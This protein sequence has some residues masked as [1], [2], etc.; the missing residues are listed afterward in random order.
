MI[1][2]YVGDVT[3]HL[4]ELA[5]QHDP[6]AT[7]IDQNNCVDLDSGTYYT[8]IG[9]VGS[10]VN[11]ALVLRQA[12]HITYARPVQWSDQVKGS[13][14]MQAWTEDYLSVFANNKVII[15]FDIKLT[16]DK[17]TMLQLEE[18]RKVSGPQLWISGCSITHGTGVTV[19]QRYGQLLADQLDLPVSFLAQPGSSLTW[20]ADQI[21]R[22][23]IRAGDTVIWGLTSHQRFPYFKNNKITH[24]TPLT[25]DRDPAFKHR[26]D[27]AFLD[28]EQ[29]IYQAVVEIHQ[30]INFCRVAGARLILAQLLGRGLEKYLHHYSEYLM[31]TDQHGRN[32][33][34]MFLDLGSDHSHPG[35]GMHQWYCEQILNKYKESK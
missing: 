21:L 1:T 17:D 27:I 22:S 4:G 7:L 14:K 29:L 23:D 31:L 33:D 9:D 8:S 5:R 11:F 16:D 32:L 13:S 18:P 20:Q 30:V 6:M 24:V 35:P 15:N 3:E 25:Y 28:S 34:D 10:L 12:T 2:V 26:V 19:N